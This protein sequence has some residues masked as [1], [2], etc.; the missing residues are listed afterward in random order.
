V[1]VLTGAAAIA[2]LYALRLNLRKQRQIGEIVTRIKEWDGAQWQ[3]LPRLHRTMPRVG[4]S[5]LFEAAIVRDAETLQLYQG[6]RRLERRQMAAL[7][8]CAAAIV[9][10]LIG[11]QS[12]GW[13]W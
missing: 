6:L 8:V 12:W 5:V 1:L 13:R 7:I 2:A 11:A 10:L 3:R 4:L 9:L